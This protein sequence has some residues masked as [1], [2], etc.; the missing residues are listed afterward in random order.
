MR[1]KC[2]RWRESFRFIWLSIRNAAALLSKWGLGAINKSLSLG[3]SVLL[4]VFLIPPFVLYLGVV[5]WRLSNVEMGNGKY[6]HSARM[7]R[8]RGPWL[9]RVRPTR[10][11]RCK[12]HTL[13][14]LVCRTG[15][16]STNLGHATHGEI[17]SSTRTVRGSATYTHRDGVRWRCDKISLPCIA[18]IRWWR[19]RKP[20]SLNVNFSERKSIKIVW[21]ALQEI[22]LGARVYEE[23]EEEGEWTV[24]HANESLVCAVARS[25]TG[26]NDKSSRS[27]IVLWIGGRD[28]E[29]NSPLIRRWGSICIWVAKRSRGRSGIWGID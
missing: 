18:P 9:G 21:V 1:V 15:K 11:E 10:G 6:F 16:C 20:H 28:G 19:R 14:G 4:P 7:V 22:S 29:F 8:R 3:R 5:P 24:S 17:S 2:V 13:V 25:W 27:R 12:F 23:E 26:N